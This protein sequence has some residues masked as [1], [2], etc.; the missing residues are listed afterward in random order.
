MQGPELVTSLLFL[1]H[2]KD[3]ECRIE[4]LKTLKCIDAESLLPLVG[5]SDVSP[6]ILDLIAKVRVE[7]GQVMKPL[8]SNGALAVETLLHVARTASEPILSLLV[9]DPDLLASDAAVVAAILDN[10]HASEEL[11]GLLGSS[12]DT[13]GGAD[14]SDSSGTKEDD[15]SPGEEEALEDVDEENL[16]KYQMS[17]DLPVAEKIKLALTGDK[18]WRSIL[19]K[20]GNKLVCGA[21]MKNP[22]ITDGE[23]LAVAKN[24]SSSD[25]LIRL[26]TL[27]NDWI[28]NYEIK[29]ALI[30]HTRTPLPKA[31]RY[32]GILSEKDLKNL[33]KSREVSSVVVN[34]ARRMLMAKEQKK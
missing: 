6:R 7:D 3:R 26:I 27:N 28:K 22:R 2:G 19:L 17:L 33:A 25:E 13:P 21:V 30:I 11:K 29:K 31:L 34:N 9:D 4:A 18:E 15:D 1:I 5:D 20:D 32:M 16:S 8:L 23:V 14:T 24:K 10:P 12:D